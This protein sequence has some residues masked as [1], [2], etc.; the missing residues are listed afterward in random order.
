MSTPNININRVMTGATYPGE[1]PVERMTIQNSLTGNPPTTFRAVVER[2]L[3]NPRRLTQEELLAITGVVANPVSVSTNLTEN[4][5]VVIVVSD[6]VSSAIPT[7]L[8]VTPLYSSHLMMPI[9][10]GEHVQVLIDDFYRYGYA[11]NARWISRMPD[12]VYV[13][14]LGFTHSDRRF[15]QEFAAIKPVAANTSRQQQTRRPEY[16][17]PNGGDTPPTNTLPAGSGI[18]PGSQAA[19]S[20]SVNP[21]QTI[22][23][24]ASGSQI[25]TFEVVP[26]WAKRASELV[27]QSPTNAL[28]V[29]GKDRTSPE[30][31]SGSYD[32]K[33]YSGTIDIVVGRGRYRR[34]PSNLG[35]STNSANDEQGAA[36]FVTSPT[37]VT[38]SRGLLEAAHSQYESAANPNDGNPDFCR[39]AAR[40]YVSQRTPGDFT[41]RLQ[42]TATGAP[43]DAMQ[44]EGLNYSPAAL[45]PLPQP[46]TSRT[47]NTV[48]EHGN[49]F[50]VAKAD[51][52]RFVAR[53]SLPSD[54]R[55][56]A[57]RVP[58]YS[59]SILLLKEG[60][61][62][63]PED[64]RAQT[65]P[66]DHLAYLFISP[67][68]RVQIDG[69]QIFLGGA[70]SAKGQFPEPDM[71]GSI[72]G[73]SSSDLS[74]GSSNDFAGPE[75]YIKWSEFKKVVEGL[76]KQI[77]NL[78]DA[79]SSVSDS[80]NVAANSSICAP[81][82]PDVAWN[83]LKQRCDQIMQNLET[84]V[85]NSRAGTNAAVYRSRS[86]RIFG[87]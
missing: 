14:D 85:G 56:A 18:S 2:V 57:N 21:Y 36:C 10:P 78:H 32:Q 24:R 65:A 30:G 34:S 60:K 71:P 4:S 82:G 76:Q 55:I 40:I 84:H 81:N 67:E 28:I 43:N 46:F 54:Q 27:L 52:L 74:P 49:S 8:L 20:I 23:L 73:F 80:I 1:L 58:E 5:L 47:E 79:L 63:S 87:C 72:E 11:G 44:P 22:Y 26:R 33:N 38:N 77:N 50:V 29:L 7:R 15:Y 35:G 75:P 9:T 48:A 41:F 59:G 19:S 62:R 53:R 68:G 69:M 45:H 17:F 25:S 70:A 86:A 37:V 16:L 6:N 66:D 39:D 31:L 3:E 61:N 51:N 64:P 42:P 12:S 13:E 83:V